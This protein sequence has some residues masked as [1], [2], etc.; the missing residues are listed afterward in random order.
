MVRAS[1]SRLRESG[2]E[3]RAAVSNLGQV[4]NSKLLQFTQL[5]E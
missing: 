5:Y 2:L 3:S 1:D 4:I